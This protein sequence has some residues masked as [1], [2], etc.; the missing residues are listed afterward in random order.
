VTLVRR[1]AVAGTFYPSRRDELRAAIEHALAGAGVTTTGGAGD[2]A[3]APKALVAPHAGYVYSG[4]VAASAYARIAPARDRI[5]RVV[6]LGPAHRVWLE[7]VAAS[8]YDAWRTPLGDVPVDRPLN[9]PVD[10]LAH[11]DE[12]SIEVHVPFLQTILGDG[13]TLV[14]LV[15]GHASPHHVAALL[16]DL[17]GGD[18]TLVVVS[19][20]LS[21]YHDHATATDLDRATATRIVTRDYEAI[22]DRDACG[23]FPLR[24]LLFAA[25]Q[26]GL[27]VELLDLRNSGDTAGPP[28]RVVGYG[29]FAVSGGR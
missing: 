22:G 1:A 25:T 3:P 8:G 29:A 19:T 5:E 7:G 14:P 11:A 12:H 20:D 10:D 9:V 21:H 27:D 28:D 18:E 23:A 15:V 24:G 13:F 4:A 26:R 2:G 17:W 6:L 16:D